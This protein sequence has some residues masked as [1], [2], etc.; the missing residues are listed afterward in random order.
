MITVAAP[1]E[2]PEV[3]VTLPSPTFG[4]SRATIVSVSTKRAMDN[5]LYTYAKNHG[6]GRLVYDLVL[7]LPKQLEFQEFVK[8]FLTSTWRLVNHAG[9]VWWVKLVGE[10]ITFTQKDRSNRAQVTLTVEGVLKYAPNTDC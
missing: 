1:A 8:R 5:T 10:P 6:R 2:L 7:T 3:L 9:E 4:D